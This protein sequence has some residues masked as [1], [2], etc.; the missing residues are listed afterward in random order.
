MC[1]NVTVGWDGASVRECQRVKT[2]VCVCVCVVSK[3]R[4]SVHSAFRGKCGA[5]REAAP[6][7]L[8]HFD[9]LFIR[10][11]EASGVFNSATTATAAEISACFFLSS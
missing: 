6:F 11:G 8:K 7:L 2:S 4:H 1:G 10:G 5:G 9:V 3:Q